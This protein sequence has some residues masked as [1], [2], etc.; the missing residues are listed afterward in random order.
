MHCDNSEDCYSVYNHSRAT[1][2]LRQEKGREGKRYLRVYIHIRF[3][4]RQEKDLSLSL[5]FIWLRQQG[6]LEALSCW[7]RKL[8]SCSESRVVAE[9]WVGYLEALIFHDHGIAEGIAEKP[10]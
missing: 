3:R 1:P 4:H 7:E 9:M 2:R 6:S 5:Y 10:I 8:F